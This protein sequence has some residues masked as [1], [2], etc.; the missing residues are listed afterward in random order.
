MQQDVTLL[1]LF[2]FFALSGIVVN[3]SIILLVFYRQLREKG[4]AVH[5]AVIE[6]AC[7]RLRAVVLTSLT[8]IAGL[9]PLLF[10]TSLQ[11]QFLIPMAT[12][13]AFGLAFATLL[14]LF[15][16]PSL[17]IIYESALIRISGDG[18]AVQAAV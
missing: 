7:S 18:E 9:S 15:V 16:M 17:L 8:T 14:V 10:E 5:E 11:A 6:A 3:D 2:G 1:S 12:T 4:L 13:L